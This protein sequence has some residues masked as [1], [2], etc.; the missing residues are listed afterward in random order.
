MMTFLSVLLGILFLGIIVLVHE[1]G[2]FLA[3]RWRKVDVEIFSIGLGPKIWGKEIDGIDF[4][5][6]AIPF[7]GY[8]KMK[9]DSPSDLNLSSENTF[10]GTHPLNRILIAF[11]GPFFNYLFAI[12]VITIILMVGFKTVGFLPRVYV[13]TSKGINYFA[14]AGVKSG[15]VVKKIE[16][17]EI[18]TFQ[19]IDAVLVYK[20]DQNVE[21]TFERDG[22]EF[23]TKVYIPKNYVNNEG[24]LGIS[25]AAKPIVGNVF[26]DSPSERAGLKSGDVILSIDGRKITFFNEISEIVS[27]SGGKE[28]S[29]TILRDG[30]RLSLEVQPK[31]DERAKRYII[32]VA[33]KIQETE[34]IVTERKETNPVVALIKGVS[35]ANEKLVELIKGI[36]LLLSGKIDFQSSVAGPIRITYFLSSAIENQVA[37][38]NLLIVVA[39]ISMA[40]GIFNL[41]PFPGLDGWHIV[42]SSIEAITRRKPSPST[43]KVIETIG[44]A[45]IIALIIFVL[46]NDIFNLLVRDLK[47][48]R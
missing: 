35:F 15:D 37:I 19:E 48:F 5:I 27:E 40:I 28:L 47:L 16:G 34:I 14:L 13:D 22:K 31:F 24:G 23:T 33:P 29:I 44:F 41:I 20:M 36:Q 25:F 1:I 38:Q 4:R 30:K 43:I 46:F 45:A 26:K 11:L 6:S 9:G 8:V 7:G 2:H 21:I 32:G 10:Y 17:K 18:R 12:I 39:I 3:A 42:L